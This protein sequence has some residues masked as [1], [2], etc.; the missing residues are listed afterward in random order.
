MATTFSS[1]ME[2]NKDIDFYAKYEPGDILGE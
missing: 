2:V 1:T